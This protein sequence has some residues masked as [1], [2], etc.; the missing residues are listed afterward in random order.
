MCTAM[1][2]CKVFIFR[3][4]TV[5]IILTSIVWELIPSSSTKGSISDIELPKIWAP[6][7][8]DQTFQVL[9]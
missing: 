1:V 6:K 8:L 5:L 7:D 3:V 4:A 2:A 9:F